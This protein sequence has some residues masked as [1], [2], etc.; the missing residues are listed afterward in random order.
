MITNGNKGLQ[1]NVRVISYYGHETSS[2]LVCESSPRN[3]VVISLGH[4]FFSK[5]KLV[6][7]ISIFVSW[8]YLK[9]T[10]RSVLK[11]L[12]ASHDNMPH[13]MEN[14]ITHLDIQGLYSM[15]KIVPNLKPKIEQI[16][17][18]KHKTYKCNG[19]RTYD[20]ERTWEY[21]L[22]NALRCGNQ[23]LLCL[24]ILWGADVDGMSQHME[25][26][27]GEWNRRRE[28]IKCYP[29]HMAVATRRIEFIKTLVEYERVDVNVATEKDHE[30]PLHWA[31]KKRDYAIFHYLFSKGA[32]NIFGI[33]ELWDF[34][35]Q[36]DLA[37]VGFLL[38]IGVELRERSGWTPF[39]HGYKPIHYAIHSAAFGNLELLKFLLNKDN[40]AVNAKTEILA[41]S[42]LH[43][44]CKGPGYLTLADFL[45]ENGADVNIVDWHGDTPLGYILKRRR[46]SD[47]NSESCIQMVR[48][49][50]Q[51]GADVE[52]IN[53]RGAKP[54]HVAA[55]SG[56]LDVLK[57]IVEEG[58]ADLNS[59]NQWGRTALQGIPSRHWDC[60]EYLKSKG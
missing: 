32:K 1:Y 23:D 54:I 46:D 10:E 45:I 44:A 35:G 50:L 39:F 57:L 59:K 13:I 3:S 26:G 49:L 38:E 48:L 4:T 56:D 9:M 6:T 27:L 24:V 28:S 8:L 2:L 20:L 43:F 29:I 12:L 5:S 53:R 36:N 51:K 7:Y 17:R 22:N 31:W 15:S 21:A 55:E 37:A 30:T 18:E 11:L 60:V 47:L 41:E 52:H 34:V 14:V 42:A 25:Y 33:K 16:C 19:G 58:K 40:V